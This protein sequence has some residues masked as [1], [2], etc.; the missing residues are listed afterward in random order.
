MWLVLVPE[1]TTLFSAEID[2]VLPGFGLFGFLNLRKKLRFLSLITYVNFS[3]Q[4]VWATSKF[5]I[6]SYLQVNFKINVI[7]FNYLALIKF[8]KLPVPRGKLWQH[9]ISV[10]SS[11]T[12]LYL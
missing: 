12:P 11:L 7:I 6:F 4:V 8:K 5:N 3:L 1:P 9:R 10:A 2:A